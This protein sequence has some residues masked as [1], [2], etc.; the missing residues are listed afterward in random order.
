MAGIFEYKGDCLDLAEVDAF[1]AKPLNHLRAELVN[2][3][4]DLA[5]E[6]RMYTL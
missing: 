3:S 1:V 4:V 6:R 5:W 2:G